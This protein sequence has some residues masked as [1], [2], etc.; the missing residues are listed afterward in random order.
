MVRNGIPEKIGTGI[1][2]L[3]S[4]FALWLMVLPLYKVF[5]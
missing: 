3:V 5:M 2:A 4:I 1:G